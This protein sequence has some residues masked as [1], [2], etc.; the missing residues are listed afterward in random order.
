MLDKDWLYK[1]GKILESQQIKISSYKEMKMENYFQKNKKKVVLK[2]K[3]LKKYN[4]NDAKNINYIN[5]N[6]QIF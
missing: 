6:Y 3:V 2:K 4:Q 1:Q 5:N